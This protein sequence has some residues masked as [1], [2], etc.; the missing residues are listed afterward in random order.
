MTEEKMR[1]NAAMERSLAEYREELE[2]E[3]GL[4]LREE[5]ENTFRDGW[6]ASAA[7][8]Q[9][10]I[11]ELIEQVEHYKTDN[12]VLS[13]C[14]EELERDVASL[15]DALK[16]AGSLLAD[17]VSVYKEDSPP[18]VRWSEQTRLL[19]KEIEYLSNATQ[20]TGEEYER[21]VKAEALREAA[22]WFDEIDT[23]SFGNERAIRRNVQAE[24]NRMAS[25][26]EGKEPK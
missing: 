10:R 20:S 3:N 23:W 9:E 2:R 17:A 5:S 21:R 8:Y 22:Q 26:L 1:D 4:V 19:Y 24:F 13:V 11:A 15:R 14:N 6:Q 16:K 25:K 7:H 18:D 12:A